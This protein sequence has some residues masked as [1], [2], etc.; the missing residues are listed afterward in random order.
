MQSDLQYLTL[1]YG[2]IRFWNSM[3][4]GRGMRVNTLIPSLS[5]SVKFSVFG[6]NLVL[7]R[8]HRELTATVE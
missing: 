1:K 5:P 4:L 3:L 7:R 2:I 8:E 6:G